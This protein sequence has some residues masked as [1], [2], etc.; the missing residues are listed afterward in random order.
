MQGYPTL[1][2]FKSAE[3]GATAVP[4]DAPAAAVFE[5]RGA[6]TTAGILNWLD[7]KTGPVC[8]TATAKKELEKL[9]AA[10]DVV[11]VGF[12]GE[13]SSSA[14]ARMFEAA[15]A[16]DETNRYV[17]GRGAELRTAYGVA[18][19]AKA[20]LLLKSFDDGEARLL[21]GG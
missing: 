16:E 1:K 15:A 19:D 8:T 11:V 12:F 6:R 7:R 3:P 18:D 17:F 21:K 13:D 4:E 5:Y 9:V 10:A 2:L 20:V 14:E